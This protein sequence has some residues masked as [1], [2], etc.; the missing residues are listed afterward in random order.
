MEG[1]AL[2]Y[3]A[4]AALAAYAAVVRLRGRKAPQ[5]KVKAK[6]AA[7]AK[8]VDVRTPAEYSGGSYP[9]AANIPLDQLPSRLGDLPKDRPLVLFCASGMRSA[10]AARLLKRAGFADL[11]NAGG[12]ADM[13]R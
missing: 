1:N 11:T 8:I 6:L 5:S 9:G 4:L 3:I 12:L 10:R 7:G 13:P 2:A